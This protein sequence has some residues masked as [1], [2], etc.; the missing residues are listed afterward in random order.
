MW[1]DMS[2]DIKSWTLIIYEIERWF[3]PRLED[4]I[5][6]VDYTHSDTP[7]QFKAAPT[8]T[9][10]A[11][12]VLN[13]FGTTAQWKIADG[14]TDATAGSYLQWLQKTNT[15]LTA[16]DTKVWNNT[17]AIAWVK[18]VVDSNATAIWTNKTAIDWVKSVV[19]SNAT[20]L[21]TNKNSYRLSEGL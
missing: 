7:L 14:S 3:G 16:V 11:N 12:S 1:V 13:L 21:T 8:A 2:K 17:T 15:D 6:F 5:E 10:N 18:T 4:D 20:A 9:Q 19:D